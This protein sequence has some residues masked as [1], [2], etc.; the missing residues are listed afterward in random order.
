M[1]LA[2]TIAAA[3]MTPP[4]AFIPN[5]WLR[6]PGVGKGPANR[7]GW[8]RVICPTLAIYGDWSSGLKAVWKDEGFT[9]SAGTRRLLREAQIREQQFARQ[10]R[11][12][13]LSAAKRAQELLRAAI[14]VTH[15]YLAAKGF[16][17]ATG[18][19]FGEHLLIP[20][21]NAWH[22][23]LMSLQQINAVGEKRFLHGARAKGGV[24]RLGRGSKIFLCE[25]YATGLSIELAAKRL[26]RD[27]MVVVCFSANNLLEVAPAFPSAVICADHD[28]TG[29]GEQIARQSGLPWVRPKMMGDFNDLHQRDGIYSVIQYLREG[30]KP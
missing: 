12:I 17:A 3:G 14:Q 21:R 4:A 11:E 20:I 23:R 2:A 9:D 7:A 16:N 30:V 8:C 1:T 13:Q 28:S 18:L 15:P 5:R 10:Q 24:Y 27:P 26:Y 19:V 29:T 22:D 25:G 6:F